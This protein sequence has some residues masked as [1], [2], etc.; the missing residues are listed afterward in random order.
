MTIEEQNQQKAK[1]AEM[2]AKF[3]EKMIAKYGSW[4]A[5]IQMCIEKGREG[6]KKS[7]SSFTSETGRAAG[8]LSAAKRKR[9]AP[10]R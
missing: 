3:K 7:G 1:Y 10:D 2:N 5:Y 6:R 8:K 9:N 4:E